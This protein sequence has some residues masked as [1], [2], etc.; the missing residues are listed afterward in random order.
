[1]V[2]KATMARLKDT[3]TVP[4]ARMMPAPRLVGKTQPTVKAFLSGMESVTY[5]QSMCEYTPETAWFNADDKTTQG[6]KFRKGQR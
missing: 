3:T 1:M 4:K 6:R 2:V 5:T